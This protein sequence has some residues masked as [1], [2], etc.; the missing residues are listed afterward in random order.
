MKKKYK[1][2]RKNFLFAKTIFK[3]FKIIANELLKQ[4]NYFLIWRTGKAIGDQVLIT[5]FAKSLNKKYSCKVITISNY[6]SLLSLSP[7]I[8]KSIS[9]DQIIF[10]KLIYY[11]LKLIEGERI[12]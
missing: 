9:W 4:I 3:P 8:T 11:F 12:I 7:W 10:F 2:I 5:G 6:S 1:D